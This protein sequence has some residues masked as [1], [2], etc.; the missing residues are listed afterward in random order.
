MFE[1][2]T[3]TRA[4]SPALI[5]CLRP[6]SVVKTLPETGS[7]L[8]QE[9]CSGTSKSRRRLASAPITQ[10]QAYCSVR[11][12]VLTRTSHRRSHDRRRA[13][14]VIEVD[15]RHP[16]RHRWGT[17]GRLTLTACAPGDTFRAECA[18]R[19]APV[20]QSCG[21]VARRLASARSRRINPC[22]IEIES[23]PRLHVDC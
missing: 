5:S 17:R 4:R 11:K 23:S 2:A 21:E 15:E 14:A 13:A 7:R 22:R 1:V 18:Q 3:R 20:C 16:G 9:E 6:C 12:I 19:S 10:L 8:Y